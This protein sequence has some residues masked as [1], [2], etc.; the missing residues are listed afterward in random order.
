MR[1]YLQDGNGPVI[2]HLMA[3]WFEHEKRP[4]IQLNSARYLDS[5]QVLCN[6]GMTAF[7]MNRL[8]AS[9][10]APSPPRHKSGLYKNIYL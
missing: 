1:L 9:S 5:D 8:G 6:N 7:Q 4:Q 3:S 2:L 10:I